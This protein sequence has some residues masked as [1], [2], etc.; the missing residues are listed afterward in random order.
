MYERRR[1]RQAEPYA[2]K[3]RSAPI[4]ML[5]RVPCMLTGLKPPHLT[6]SLLLLKPAR[7]LTVAPASGLFLREQRPTTTPGELKSWTFSEP[8]GHPMSHCTVL[9]C[10]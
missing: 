5:G 8:C 7:L 4:A 9:Q 2:V 6:F 3:G 10:I 1:R